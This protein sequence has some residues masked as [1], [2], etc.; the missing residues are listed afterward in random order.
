[1]RATLPSSTGS[2]GRIVQMK[3]RLQPGEDRSGGIVRAGTIVFKRRRL[4]VIMMRG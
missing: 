2:P 1:M 3:G 4:Q